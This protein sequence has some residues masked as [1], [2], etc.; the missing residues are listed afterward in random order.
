[1][2]ETEEGLWQEIVKKK[3]IKQSPICLIQEK[4]SDSPLWKDLLKI[5]QVY[6]KGRE[7]KINNGKSVSFW[8]DRWLEDEPLCVIYPTLFDSCS[9]KRISVYEVWSEVWVIHFQMIPQG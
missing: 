3:Y 4:M 2:L 1:M 5:R 8:L 7:Y 6:L 9:N